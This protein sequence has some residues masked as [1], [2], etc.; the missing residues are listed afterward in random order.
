[1]RINLIHDAKTLM[2]RDYSRVL[3][4]REKRRTLLKKV[5][6]TFFLTAAFITFI[7]LSS[8]APVL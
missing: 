6:F 3:E 1:M 5:A 4:L 7:L 8:L 2:I